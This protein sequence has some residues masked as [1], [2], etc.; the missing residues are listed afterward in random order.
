M[1]AVQVMAC[2]GMFCNR[3]GHLRN[4]LVFHQTLNCFFKCSG[5]DGDRWDPFLL[6]IELVNY[7]P[8]GAGPSVRLCGNDQVRFQLGNGCRHLFTR[9]QI[10]GNGRCAFVRLPQLDDLHVFHL[11]G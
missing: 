5:H 2:D 11:L 7:Q 10:L 3:Q 8:L 9:L 1:D 4:P 6:D